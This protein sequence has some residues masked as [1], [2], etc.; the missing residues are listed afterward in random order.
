MVYYIHVAQMKHADVAQSVERIL[1]KDEVAGSNPAISSRKATC[2][3][4]VFLCVLH[5][6]HVA[7]GSVRYMLSR[8]NPALPLLRQYVRRHAVSELVSAPQ[9]LIN[10]LIRRACASPVRA[11]PSRS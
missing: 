11:P 7:F 8:L 2:Y 5:R 4:V 9:R 1:G 10:S 6:N 3:R